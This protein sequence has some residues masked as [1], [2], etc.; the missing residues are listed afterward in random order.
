MRTLL[1]VLA[2][3]AAAAHAQTRSEQRT[4]DYPVR[5]LR[6][7]VTVP[8]GGGVDSATRAMAQKMSE[9]TGVNVI[10]DN[11][12]GGTGTIAMNITRQSAPDGYTVLS[13]SNSMVVTGVLGKVPYD[14]RTAF[15]PVVQMTSS[16]YVVTTNPL[17]NVSSIKE[18]IALAR[19]KPGALSYGTPGMGSIVH[20]GTEQFA[21]AAGGL[22]LVHVPYK[23]NGFAIIDLLAGR[24]EVI[25]AAAGVATH[26]K[27]G[28][29]KALAVTS[30]RRMQAFPDLPTVSESG[31]SGFVMENAYGLYAPAGVRPEIRLALNKEV[32]LAINSPE[33]KDRIATDG[34]EPAAP[35]TPAQFKAQFL[36]QY[37]QLSKFIR[38]SGIKVE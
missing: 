7:I 12:V 2:C 21:L 11:R 5:P 37:E 35:H 31:V 15:D 26:I 29:L 20:L 9:R 6:I 22:R 28:R 4:N 10:V 30:R 25:F 23:G 36:E 18:L 17:L 8:A 34:A 1:L 16:A 24:I 27:N 14:I 38:T 19:A 13:S 33:A 32:S 3:T